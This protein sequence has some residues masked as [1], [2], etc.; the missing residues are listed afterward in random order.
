MIRVYRVIS[1][2]WVFLEEGK[3][4]WAKSTPRPVQELYKE[5]GYVRIFYDD[6]WGVAYPMIE[7][8]K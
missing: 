1:N 4:F 2:G 5:H 8:D 6:S 3:E 7:V